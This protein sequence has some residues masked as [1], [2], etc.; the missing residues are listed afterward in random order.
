MRDGTPSGPL[1][2]LSHAGADT[3]AARVLKQRIEGAPEARKRINCDESTV[4]N[5]YAGWP[6]GALCRYR[7]MKIGRR[8]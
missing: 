7:E 2:F 3:E 4:M 6:I 8:V 5:R 1:L